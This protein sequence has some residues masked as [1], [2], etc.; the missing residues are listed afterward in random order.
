LMGKPSG[1]ISSNS[2]SDICRGV[3]FATISSAIPFSLVSCGA[4]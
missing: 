4:I 3:A 1:N 2:P